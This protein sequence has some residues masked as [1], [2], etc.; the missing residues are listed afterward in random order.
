MKIIK[1][2]QI[3]TPRLILKPVTSEDEERLIDILINE[4][5]A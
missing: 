3:Q 4:E 5:I 1:K 2:T